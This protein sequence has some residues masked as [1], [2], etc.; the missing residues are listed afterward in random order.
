MVAGV[1]DAGWQPELRGKG[2]LFE[3][4]VSSRVHFQEFD[5]CC[6]C[7]LSARMRVWC[8][9]ALQLGDDCRQCAAG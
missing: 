5:L 6:R 7:L 8:P 1:R 2:C 4:K 3:L 9:C